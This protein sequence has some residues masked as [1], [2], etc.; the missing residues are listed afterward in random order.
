MLVVIGVVNSES[1]MQ[2]IPWQNFQTQ[3]KSHDCSELKSPKLQAKPTLA[4]SFLLKEF[5]IKRFCHFD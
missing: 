4:L 1:K 3:L 5:S 2:K